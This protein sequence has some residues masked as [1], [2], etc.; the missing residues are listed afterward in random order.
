MIS[1]EER[2]A[3]AEK[4]RSI[5]RS[6]RKLEDDLQKALDEREGDQ[7]CRIQT[8]I[9]ILKIFLE[10]LVLSSK[11]TGYQEK[12]AARGLKLEVSRELLKQLALQD[13]VLV[14]CLTSDNCEL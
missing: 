4:K 13:R 11:D 2:D 12:L 7:I 6:L 8:L 3:L 14:S 5:T 9:Q 10:H 1:A